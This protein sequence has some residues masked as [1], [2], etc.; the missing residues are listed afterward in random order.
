MLKYD[1]IVKKILK[2]PFDYGWE[3]QG[4]GMLRTYIDKDT[5]LQIWLKDFIVPGVTDIHTHPWDFISHIY[6]GKITNHT[7]LKLDY[8]ESDLDKGEIYDEC[9]ILTGENAHVKEI[10]E[11]IL[12]KFLSATYFAG[13]EYRHNSHLPHRIDFDD[14]TITILTKLNIQEESIANSYVPESGV[15]VSAAPRLATPEEIEKFITAASK[16][17]ENISPTIEDMFSKYNDVIT[18]FF[19]DEKT[20]EKEIHKLIDEFNEHYKIVPKGE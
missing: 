16:L 8:N 9:V 3:L 10:K 4:F 17:N 1:Y 6:Q 15:W 11:V 18:S 2:N 19:L 7:F 13:H 12:H 14:G 5:R 20:G